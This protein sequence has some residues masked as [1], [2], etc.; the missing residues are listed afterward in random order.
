MIFLSKALVKW[1][2]YRSGVIFF[3]LQEFIQAITKPLAQI[4]QRIVMF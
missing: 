1:D 3:F 2:R 4:Q